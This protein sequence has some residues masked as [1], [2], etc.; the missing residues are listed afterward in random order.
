MEGQTTDSKVWE[1]AFPI[2]F[3][4]LVNR[5]F[6]KGITS[7]STEIV[8]FS[9]EIEIFDMHQPGLNGWFILIMISREW[10]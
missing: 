8:I 2:Q 7:N 10:K 1:S 9:M 4:I 5:D 6:S 3:S